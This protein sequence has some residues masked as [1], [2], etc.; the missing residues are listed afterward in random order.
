[1][2]PAADLPGRLPAGC[3]TVV[4]VEGVSDA[5]A[6]TALAHRFGHDL[7]RDGVHVLPMGGVTNVGAYVRAAGPSGLGLRL[8]GLCDA[9]E[10]RH[11]VRALERA[12]L[13]CT[14]AADLDTAGFSVCDADLE[15]EL[16]RA[17]GVA[18][19]EQVVAAQGRLA[20]FRVLQRQPAQ[21][22]RTPAEQLHRFIGAR[23][24]HKHRYAALLVEALDLD[25]VPPPLDRLLARLA[26]G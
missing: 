22:D 8:T 17:V 13:G 3:R 24:G 15:D 7:V 26:R 16:I 18:G 1:M 11:V 12:G 9:G 25:R 19:V 21:R 5:V 4:L 10:V 2:D 14:S 6:V 20:S 23:S